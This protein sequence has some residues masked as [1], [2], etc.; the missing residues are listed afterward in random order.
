MYLIVVRAAGPGGRTPNQAEAFRSAVLAC[1]EPEN[2]LQHVFAETDQDGIAA[3]LFMTAASVEAAERAARRL[4]ERAI[5]GAGAGGNAGG[6]AGG[7]PAGLVLGSCQASLVPAVE[8]M[9]IRR[10]ADS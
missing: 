2:R 4:C 5:A 7:G 1:A 6:G 3:V 9:R 10:C 8:E